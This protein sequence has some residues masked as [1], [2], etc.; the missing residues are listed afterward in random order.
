MQVL[1]NTYKSRCIAYDDDAYNLPLDTIYFIESKWNYRLNEYVYIHQREIEQLFQEK[2]DGLYSYKLEIVSLNNLKNPLVR[3]AIQELHPEIEE[4]IDFSLIE[5][6][7]LADRERVYQNAMLQRLLSKE[8]FYEETFIVRSIPKENIDLYEFYSIDISL[9]SESLILN[10]LGK[11]IDDINYLNLSILGEQEFWRSYD[12]HNEVLNF[13][14]DDF[15]FGGCESKDCCEAISQESDVIISND[16][17]IDKLNINPQLRELALKIRDEINTYQR[18]NGVNILL[19]NICDDFL[20]SFEKLE[21]KPL[22]VLEVDNTFNIY[23]REY[24][25]EVKMYTLPKTIYLFFLRHPQ[26][27]YLKDIADYR[28]ELIQIY[29]LLTKKGDSIK[30][31][32]AVIDRIIDTTQGNLLCQYMSRISEAFRNVLS[33]DLAKK[34]TIAG[35]RNELRRVTLDSTKI[36]LP[37]NLKKLDATLRF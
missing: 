17:E 15:S 18:E 12:I 34:Y 6:N 31:S 13:P 5:D 32:E 21:T 23:L 28:G 22:S 8:L 27:I 37:E 7:T 10:L 3:K 11:F 2:N 16:T 14:E 30:E 4:D 24:K 36:L 25:K 29:R 35:K 9:C 26:G 20:K 1:R 19:E 33:T